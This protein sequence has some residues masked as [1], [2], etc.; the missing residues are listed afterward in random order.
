MAFGDAFF[1]FV[2]D[3]QIGQFIYEGDNP[4]LFFTVE[5]VISL[6]KDG[7]VSDGT[8][9]GLVIGKFHYEGGVHMLQPSGDKFKYAGEMEGY[10]YLVNE[11]ATEKHIDRL[12]VLNEQTKIDHSIQPKPFFVP[13]NIK[14]IDV[15]H[16]GI[17]IL[18]ISWRG[19]FIANR[20]AS[21]TNLILL[22]SINS[23]E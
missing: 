2:H 15:R 6:V 11:F 9:G 21:E 20:A 10:E 17:E 16:T 12:S 23:E 7:Q 1:S 18:L 14:V 22:D 4:G 5:E 19:H 3:R 8:T 13:D